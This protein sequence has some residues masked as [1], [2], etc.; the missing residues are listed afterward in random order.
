MQSD[1]DEDVRSAAF[2]ALLHLRGLLPFMRFQEKD[3]MEAQAI[4]PSLEELERIIA[5]RVPSAGTDPNA[6]G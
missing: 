1:A 3:R 6:P 5:R 4:E 2:G